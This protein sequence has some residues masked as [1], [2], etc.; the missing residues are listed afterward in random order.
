MAAFASARLLLETPP[1]EPL[2][3]AGHHVHTNTAG[4]GLASLE[5]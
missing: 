3:A 5:L 4:P 1:A 2:S